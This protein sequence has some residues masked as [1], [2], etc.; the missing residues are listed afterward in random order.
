[1]TKVKPS[2]AQVQA[3]NWRSSF[4]SCP[5]VYVQCAA[6]ERNVH[7]QQCHHHFIHERTQGEEKASYVGIP[8]ERR[9]LIGAA[10][11]LGA[12]RAPREICYS[13]RLINQRMDD[14]ERGYVVDDDP[15][16]PSAGS[17]ASAVW[18]ETQNP[19]LVLM[20]VELE[21]GVQGKLTSITTMVGV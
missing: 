21:G 9:V 14:G 13:F 16:I 2:G 6:G 18:G 15:T 17:Q 7:G 10:E 12:V 20:L 1:M 11:Q 4:S 3:V 8:E 5:A 19:H